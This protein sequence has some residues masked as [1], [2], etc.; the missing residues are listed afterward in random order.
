MKALP[1]DAEF[2]KRSSKFVLLQVDTKNGRSNPCARLGLNRNRTYFLVLDARGNEIV[3][4]FG[5]GPRKRHSLPA[6]N[7]PAVRSVLTQVQRPPTGHI[8]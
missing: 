4:I 2:N 3:R 7:H 5:P 8:A 6:P 1:D